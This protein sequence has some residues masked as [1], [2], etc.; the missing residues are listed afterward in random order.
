MVLPEVDKRPLTEHLLSEVTRGLDGRNR[1]EI[2]DFEPSRSL[3]AG[4]LQPAREHLDAS[5]ATSGGSAIGLDFRV[6]PA[7]PG[8]PIRLRVSAA[9]SHYFAVFPTWDQ[10]IEA[11]AAEAEPDSEQDTE[12]GAAVERNPEEADVTEVSLSGDTGVMSADARDETNGAFHLPHHSGRLILPRVF[13]R[14]EARVPQKAVVIGVVPEEMELAAAECDSALQQVRAAITANP[15]TWRHLAAPEK[16][17]RELG[18]S[19]E[20]PNAD[21]YE[22]ALSA[23]KGS[24]VI[25]PSWK[26]RI[27]VDAMPDPSISDVVRIRVLLDNRTPAREEQAGTAGEDRAPLIEPD[28]L[29]QER[30]LFD[31]ALEVVVENG[32]VV[33]FDFLQA[34]SDYRTR[35]Q[36]PAKGVNCV[37]VQDKDNPQR[38]VTETLPVFRQP[39][40]RTRDDLSVPFE[41]LVGSEYLSTLNTVEQEMIKYLATWDRYLATSGATSLSPDGLTACRNDRD[42]FQDEIARFRLGVQ[43]LEREPRL[44]KAFRGM[45][46]AFTRLGKASGGRV[47]A[48]RLFQI[49]FIVSQLPALAVR[50]LAVGEHD[51]YASDLRAAHE[52]VG[53]LWFPTGGGKTEAYLGLIGVGLLYDRLRGKSRGICAWMRFPLRMLS[54]QQLER[55]AKVLAALEVFRSQ[56]PELAAGDPFAIGYFVGDGVTPNSISEDEMRKLERDARYREEKRLIR[57]CPFC[58][59]PVE[60]RAQ[61]SDWRLTHVCTDPACFT[62]TSDSLGPYK[63]S[64]PV[65]IVD[66]EIYRYLPSVLVGTVDKLAIVG[67][68]RHFAHLVG[69]VRQRCPVHGYTS[70][71]ECIEHWAGCKAKKRDLQKLAP[72]PD[73]GISLLIQDEFHLLRAELGVFNGHYEGLLRYLGDEAHLAPKVLAATATIEAYD[74]HAFHVY[75]SRARRFPQPSWTNGE[76]FY[77]T[78]TPYMERRYY[79]GVRSHTRAV[80][81][82]IIRICTLYQ[83]AVRRL[84]ADPRAAASVLGR[85]DLSD[86][87]VQDILRLYDLSL[88]YVNR[89]ATG[90]S[91]VDK[92]SRAERRLEAEG[93]GSIQRQLLTGDQ[94]MEEVG[95]AIDRI[96]RERQ[97]TGDERLDVVIA[98]NLISH[99]V[100]LERINM[101]AVAGMPSHY[102]EY[103]Q[104]TSRAARSHPGIV[105]V[106]FQS[107]DPREN[108]QYEFFPAMHQNMDRLVEAVAVNRFSSFAP[109][110]TVP[111]L[112]SGVLLCALSPALYAAGKIAKPL[113]HLPT[114]KVALGKVPPSTVGTQGGVVSEDSLR[115]ALLKII[116]A[117]RDRPPA[118][119]AQIRNTRQQ[120]ESALSE[121]LDLI[122]R[123]LDNQL[124]NVIQP[125]TSFRDVDEG[126]EFGSVNSSNFVTRLRAY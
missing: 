28:R 47:V 116:G 23:V 18:N 21:A 79:V 122:G 12:V 29:L 104:S 66:N 31:C 99:G 54:L 93:L 64:L 121:N 42:R 40:Y 78:S 56:T 53:I 11:G 34:P 86:N 15:R 20:I 4:V 43:T 102:A 52:E 115:D 100:D 57:K 32:L 109:W 123:G 46:T 106:C 84:K 97:D 114:L 58:N 90:G 19:S 69:G 51:S 36:M 45:N 80:E 39:H 26:V 1:E 82:P 72:V 94:R 17:E 68:S 92:L 74:I 65:C 7:V 112:L 8:E 85:V 24:K 62:H 120:V 119:P 77:A 71:D 117:D 67:R 30:A 125:I 27:V 25:Q 50:E 105:F 16:N 44:A 49:G 75:L 35:P 76:S 5:V 101:M 111:G 98:T 2:V 107:R 113:D 14:V 70:Y 60:V 87:Q 110:K 95:T 103:V 10:L 6:K 37:A 22:T 88:V 3:F 41:S 48:W 63:G 55:L 38:L 81:D 89:K 33:P 59:Q 91:I 108:S 73:P 126:I 13:S 96:E 9:W 118:S 83:T 61:R 124:K